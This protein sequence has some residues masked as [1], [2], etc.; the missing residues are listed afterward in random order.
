MSVTI[1]SLELNSQV[2]RSPTTKIIF[3]RNL[4]GPSLD[5]DAMAVATD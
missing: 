3:H 4:P 5:A 2:I 1:D